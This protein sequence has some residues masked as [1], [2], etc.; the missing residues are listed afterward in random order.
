MTYER[1]IDGGFK[2][3]ACDGFGGSQEDGPCN[4]C[5][6]DGQARCDMK[7]GETAVVIH[8]GLPVCKAH[9]CADCDA[10]SAAALRL[11]LKIHCGTHP[12]VSL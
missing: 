8:D 1:H 12:V 6:G 3:R 9:R 10:V 11:T 7:C 2:C 4:A 5:G